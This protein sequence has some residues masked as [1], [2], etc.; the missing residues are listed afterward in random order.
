M[1]IQAAE[2]PGGLDVPQLKAPAG[3]CDTHMHVIYPEKRFPFIQ[4]KGGV[5]PEHS[6]AAYR[7]AAKSLGIE[8]CVVVLPPF[9]DFDN[10]SALAAVQEVAM[11]AR[12]VV[13][14]GPDVTP[15]ELAALHASG[16]R[17]ANFFMLPGGCLEWEA[18][19]PVAAK[20]NE[21]GWHVQVQLD[22][23]T[24]ADHADRL[25]RLP[26]PV[27]IDHI[28]KFLGPAGLDHPGFVALLRLLDAGKTYV[29][30]SAPYESSTDAPPYMKD[31]GLRAA[32]LVKAAPE[33]MLWASNWPHL[34]DPDLAAKPRNAPL[35]DTLLAWV[36]DAPVREAILVANPA[37]LYG[38]DQGSV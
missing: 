37:R 15:E 25:A 35:L 19:D 30:L 21:L 12:A 8:R 14:V 33:R 24:L 27:V 6:C 2:I 31:A 38:F 7:E 23:R 17:A 11:P 13:N 4:G 22:G 18:L 28:G 29:K 32:A 5:F 34:G 9:Y 10:R 3:T 1:V 20:V 36:E 26:T 16:A